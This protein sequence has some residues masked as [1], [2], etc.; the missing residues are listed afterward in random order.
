MQLHTAHSPSGFHAAQPIV[1]LLNVEHE[2]VRA[3]C[4]LRNALDLF[5]G[6]I[7]LVSSFGADAAVLLHMLA[8]FD[9]D[10]PVIFLDTGR[11]FEKTLHYRQTLAHQLGLRNVRSSLPNRLALAELDP[12]GSLHQLDPDA[13]CAI[14]KKAVLKSALSPFSAWISGRKRY[15]TAARQNIRIFECDN[16]MRIKLSPLADWSEQDIEHYYEAHKLPRHPLWAEGYRSIGCAPCTSPTIQGE[17]ARD[18][19]WSARGKTEC[20]IHL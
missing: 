11:H 6:E 19:R 13:C 5:S 1:D 4:I 8:E 14:R 20:G 15:Q 16:E 18:G 3:E 17:D 12:D 9:K 2:N 7:V 10:I